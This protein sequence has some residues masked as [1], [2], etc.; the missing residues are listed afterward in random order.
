MEPGRSGC[1][2]R[3]IYI[4]ENENT[5]EESLGRVRFKIKLAP[6]GQHDYRD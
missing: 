4:N 3:G 6:S 2:R 1:L 5:A